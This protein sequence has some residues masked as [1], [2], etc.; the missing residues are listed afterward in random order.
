MCL[1]ESLPIPEEYKDDSTE[2][3]GYKVFI[4][5][6]KRYKSPINGQQLYRV[7]KWVGDPKTMSD[8][9]Y[10]IYGDKSYK[11]GFHIFLCAADATMWL[12]DNSQR[13]DTRDT[14][15][16]TYILLY[17]KS[18]VVKRIKYKHVVAYGD[19]RVG[20]LKA[21]CVVV[22]YMYIVDQ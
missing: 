12:R 14:V 4:Q 6:D 21:K 3:I 9:F 18:L 1:V 7:N 22:E 8:S 11:A 17:L 20:T 19:Q 13:L 2:H 10:P 16:N 5:R 15:N